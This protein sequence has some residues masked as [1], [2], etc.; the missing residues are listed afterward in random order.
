[1]R[2][3]AADVVETRDLIEQVDAVLVRIDCEF[4]FMGDTP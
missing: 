2:R 3:T 1:L 4:A